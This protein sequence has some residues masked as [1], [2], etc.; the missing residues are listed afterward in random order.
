[1]VLPRKKPKGD[2]ADREQNCMS[3]KPKSMTR[4]SHESNRADHEHDNSCDHHPAEKVERLQPGI[5]PI[6]QFYDKFD[7]VAERDRWTQN[8]NQFANANEPGNNI[9]NAIA[10]FCEQRA[11][12]FSSNKNRDRPDQDRQQGESKTSA[13]DR[14]DNAFV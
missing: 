8:E 3:P 5:D 6:A 1:M 12:I 14:S 10:R 13:D 7:A 9:Q 11:L 4:K 2:A